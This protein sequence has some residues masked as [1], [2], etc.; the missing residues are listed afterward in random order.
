MEKVLLQLAHLH[1]ALTLELQLVLPFS[2]NIRPLGL[3][4]RVHALTLQRRRRHSKVHEGHSAA[5]VR[6]ELRCGVAGAHVHLEGGAEIDVLIAE[7]DQHPRPA[8]VGLPVEHIVEDRI[9]LVHIHHNERGSKAQRGLQALH[10]AVLH[11][12]CLQE[13][14]VLKLVA[15]KRD[16]LTRWVDDQGISQESPHDDGILVAK[17]VI[18]KCILLP[19]EALGRFGQVFDDGNILLLLDFG[20]VQFLSPKLDNSLTHEE[21]KEANVRAKG[22][23][24]QNISD[25]AGRLLLKSL[26]RALPSYFL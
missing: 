9:H 15:Q 22:T 19:L 17:V 11:K 18:R 23:T 25:H 5:K 13:L 20:F 26:G 12:G 6:R 21:I 3:Q 8:F 2:V 7:S 10:K 16:R 24:N 14:L 4:Q 1:L